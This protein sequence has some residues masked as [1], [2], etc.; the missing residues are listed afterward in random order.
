MYGLTAHLTLNGRVSAPQLPELLRI[1]ELWA[2]LGGRGV[3]LRDPG[4]LM[5]LRERFDFFCTVSL[6]T[7]TVNPEGAAFWRD[8]GAQ[9]LVL[10]R[11]LCP[12][13]MAA[14]TAGAPELEYE[15]MVMGDRCPFVDGFCRSVH[16]ESFAPAPPDLPVVG[17]RETCNPSG[18]AF[19]LCSDF[20]APAQD[21]CAACR[22]GELER[23]GIA[24]GKLGMKA[25][26]EDQVQ[27]YS[28]EEAPGHVR[29]FQDI[30]EE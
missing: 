23:S 2:Q 10:P 14:V 15:A 16:A 5:L 13:E 19:H 17:I 25:P 29:Q 1:A 22:L 21:P 9:R 6:L 11:F 28:I 27:Y 30:A 26:S 24:I 20:C 4:L 12:E 3:I 7:V 8:L 18:N